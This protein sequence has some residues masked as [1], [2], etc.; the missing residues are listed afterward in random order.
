MEVAMIRSISL[1]GILGILIFAGCVSEPKE[2]PE[3]KYGAPIPKQTSTTISDLYRNQGMHINNQVIVSGSIKSISE[4]LGISTF[5]LTSGTDVVRCSFEGTKLPKS[6]EGKNA[7][8]IGTLVV[9][10]ISSEKGR[11]PGGEYTFSADPSGGSYKEELRIDVK[12]LQ[13]MQNDK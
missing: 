6:L 1:L 3:G 5:E 10:Q 8:V 12:G 11:Q 2:N 4:Q 9:I 13:L 7:T